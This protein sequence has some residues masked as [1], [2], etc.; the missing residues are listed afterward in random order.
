MEL[1]DR[2]RRIFA[3]L[4]SQLSTAKSRRFKAAG[5]GGR[6][7]WTILPSAVLGVL[8]TVSGMILGLGSALL[9][10][11]FLLGWWLYPTLPTLV[12]VAGRVARLLAGEGPP[13]RP[14]DT[15]H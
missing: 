15:G 5:R 6:P 10:G 9:M 4:E 12:R 14:R 8:L 3:E 7:Q 11:S 1:T 13:R 2:E